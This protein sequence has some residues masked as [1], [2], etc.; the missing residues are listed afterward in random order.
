M[1]KYFLLAFLACAMLS[2]CETT[3]DP[4]HGGLF[5]W[6]ES[7]TNA[8]LDA[9]E[10]YLDEVE[11]DTEYQRRRARGLEEERTRRQRELNRLQ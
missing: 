4:A 3:G 8:R 6:S 5:Q 1:S 9:K 10:D 2:S 7:K 11:R